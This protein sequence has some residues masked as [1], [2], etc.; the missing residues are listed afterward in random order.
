MK[1]QIYTG[2][3][4]EMGVDVIGYYNEEDNQLMD[5]FAVEDVF[6]ANGQTLPVISIL[7]SVGFTFDN[8]GDR[9]SYV[10]DVEDIKYFRP[11]SEYHLLT[12]QILLEDYKKMVNISNIDEYKE[13]MTK[14]NTEVNIDESKELLG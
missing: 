14:S 13:L 8:I 10:L 9:L 5:V 2:W 4:N 3:S 12:N 7:R 1:L 11:L 6:N